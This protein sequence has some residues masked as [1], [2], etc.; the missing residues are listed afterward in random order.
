MAFTLNN[1]SSN[2]NTD[3]PLTRLGEVLDQIHDHRMSSPLED[4]FRF[5]PS[6]VRI[7]PAVRNPRIARLGE[8]S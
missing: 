7:N 3:R 2:G 4:D 8:V 5:C 1:N 6:G